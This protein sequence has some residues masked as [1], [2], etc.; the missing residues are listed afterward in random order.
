[1]KVTPYNTGK[2]LI[3]CMWQPKPPPM[4]QD[5]ELIQS[6]LLGEPVPSF[7]VRRMARLAWLVVLFFIFFSI[8]I[9]GC[10]NA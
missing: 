5:E 10:T 7:R 1:M 3:G 6:V 8:S 4:S 2:V 9:K